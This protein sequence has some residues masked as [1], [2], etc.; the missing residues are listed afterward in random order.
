[1]RILSI[2]ES[3]WLNVT[4][5]VAWRQITSLEDWPSWHPGID[6]AR[7]LGR[8]G[9]TP[10]HRFRLS[11]LESRVPFLAVGSVCEVVDGHSVGWIGKFLTLRVEFKLA[12]TPEGCGSRIDYSAT[13][14]GAAVRWVGHDSVVRALSRFLRQ[15]LAALRES[16]E[17]LSYSETWT[18]VHQR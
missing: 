8:C 1:M 10:G 14:R 13:V 9:W 3:T 15:T 12:V 11:L 18:E 16:G 7:W 17:T 2:R 4:P 6:R 5:G